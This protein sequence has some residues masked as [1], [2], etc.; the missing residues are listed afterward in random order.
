[1]VAPNEKK[2]RIEV[3]YGLEG[4]L[5]DAISNQIISSVMIPEF[6]NGKM[7]EGVKEGVFAFIFAVFF[8][9]LKDVFKRNSHGGSV[10]MGFRRGGSGS[11]GGGG[12]SNGRG[13]G[14]GG[15]GDSGGW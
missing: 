12:C 2:V 8:L 13:V 9:I 3:G 15:G 7:S 14:F 1:M 10:S 5:T 11:N 4:M 6:K